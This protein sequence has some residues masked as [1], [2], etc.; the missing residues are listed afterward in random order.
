[1]CFDHLTSSYR[2]GGS[3]GSQGLEQLAEEEG[4]QQQAALSLRI[5]VM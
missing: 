4:E 2:G 3:G 1:M 5:Q